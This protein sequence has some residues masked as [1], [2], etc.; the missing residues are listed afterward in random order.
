MST[1]YR[2]LCGIIS[3]LQA[4]EHFIIGSPHPIK[5]F[6]DHKPLLNLWARRGRLY[7]RFFRYQ[8]IITQFT[9]LHINWTPE[10]NPAFPDLLSRNVSLKDLDGHQLVHKEIRTDIRFFNQSGDEVQYLIDHNSSADDGKDDFYPIVCTHL[11][12]TKALHLK[13]D[14]TEMICTIFDSRSPK[15]LFNVSHSFREGK[16]INNRRRRQAPPN[17]VEAEVHENYYSEIE[18]N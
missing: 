4:Y 8:V 17:V 15:A 3:A 5:N 16:N 2:E 1:L 12:E 6:C 11:G 10:K 18:C 13:N 14:G 9:N 7:H